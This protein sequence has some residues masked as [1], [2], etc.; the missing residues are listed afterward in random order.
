MPRLLLTAGP[1][2]EPIDAVRFI[3]NRSSGRMGLAIASA[4]A[5]AGWSTTLLLGPGPEPPSGPI[6]TIRFE[7][8]AQLGALLNAHWPDHDVLIMAAAVADERPT[9]GPLSGKQTR[10]AARTLALE[11]TPDLLESL[12][13][14]TRD[15]PYRIG[16]ALESPDRMV[17]RA[18]KK[19][20]SKR[21]D[22]IVANPLD[23]ME[24]DSVDARLIL[25]TG[26]EIAAPAGIDKATFAAWLLQEITNQLSHRDGRKT[27][28]S[29]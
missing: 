19:L 8:T 20:A 4:A 11:P 7:T 17:E 13:P 29:G 1:T 22:A 24:S 14:M 9:G 21:L 25:R 2:R 10:G 6:N 3:G 16:F 28:T 26:E 15:D 12:A 23:T 27:I 18:R 5:D